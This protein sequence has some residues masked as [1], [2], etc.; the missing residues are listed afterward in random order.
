MQSLCK[1]ETEENMDLSE[2]SLLYQIKLALGMK[3]I[4]K[5]FSLIVCILTSQG[6]RSY[7][8][9][10]TANSDNLLIYL[11]LILALTM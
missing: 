3:C 1:E 4:A 6:S 5:M 7:V 2:K 9:L 10:S 11:L 8:K